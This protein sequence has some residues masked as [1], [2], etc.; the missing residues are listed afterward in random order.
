[1][2]VPFVDLQAQYRSIKQEIDQAIASV[3][4]EASFIGGKHLESFEGHFASYTGARHCIGVGNG[5]DAISIAL[6]ALGI[7]PGDEVI[8]AANSFIASSEAVT[9]AGARVV[10]VDCDRSTY[11]LDAGALERAVTKRTKAVIPVHLYGQPADMD[12]IAGVAQRHGLRIIE[13]AAQAH[14]A[15]Y[16]GRTV[17]TLGDC[18]CFSFYPGKNLG[19]Y[20]DGGAITTSDHDLAKKIRMFANHGRIEKY[21]HEFEGVNSRLDSLQAAV[22]DVKLRH[23]E[24][25]TERRRAVARRYDDGLRGS[26][27]IPAVLPDC[28]HVY[29]LYVVRVPRREAV[30][31]FLKEKGIG[32]GIHYPIPLPL[33]NAYRYL[34]HTAADFPVASSLKDEILSLPMYGDLTDDQADMVIA[35]LREAVSRTT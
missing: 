12:A 11:T 17:G 27:V 16:R 3:V 22:L 33:L 9:A 10:F 23:L 25:W 28:R 6:K 7:G 24:A 18:A 35:S 13:D 19:A 34:G 31:K 14:G 1:M 21:N 20:G 4:S 5:T 29:H 26:V 8:T 30:I 32:T 15:R 2:N